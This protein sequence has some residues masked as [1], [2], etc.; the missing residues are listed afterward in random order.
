MKPLN[1]HTL[2]LQG[3]ILIEASAGTGKTYSISHI[4]LRLILE[5][6]PQLQESPLTIQD[7]LVVTFTKA[8]T[9][10]LRERIRR[11]LHEAQSYLEAT[12]ENQE[13][14]DENLRL[15]VTNA[16]NQ[17]PKDILLHRL[18][19]AILHIDEAPVFTIHGLCERLLRQ[20]GLLLRTPVNLSL[21]ENDTDFLQ[22]QVDDFWRAYAYRCSEAEAALVH[23]CWQSPEHL[24]YQLRAFLDEDLIE[25]ANAKDFSSTLNQIDHLYEQAKRLFLDVVDELP[26]IFA[27]KGRKA[28]YRKNW[29]EGWIRLHHNYFD[30]PS[31]RYLPFG[32]KDQWLRFTQDFLN[33]KLAQHAPSHPF[34]EAMNELV[35]HI[36]SVKPSFYA[37]ARSELIERVANEKQVQQACFF[38]DLVKRVAKGALDAEFCNAVAN[39]FPVALI[40]EFQ[41]TDGYQYQL[42][43]QIYHADTRCLLMIGDPKQAIYSFRGADIKTYLLAR[44]AVSP[45]NRYSLSTNHRTQPALIQQVNALFQVKE[46]PFLLPTFP[47]FIPSAAPN[48]KQ[49]DALLTMH[50]TPYPAVALSLEAEDEKPLT[51]A[52]AKEQAAQKTATWIRQLLAS[53][54]IAGS[55]VAPKSIAILVRKNSQ[56][57][58]MKKALL[59]QGLNSIFLSK[60]SVLRSDESLSLLRLF[61][62]VV[63]PASRSQLYL[64]LSDD[65]IALSSI[66]LSQLEQDAQALLAHQAHF[67]QAQTLWREKGFYSAFHYLNQTY[68]IASR[69]LSHH[70][71]ERKWMNLQQSAECFSH[72]GSKHL[73]I[74]EQ[75][76]LYLAQ[77]KDPR[78]DEESQKYRLETEANLINIVTVHG[79]KG[80]EYPIVCCP[81]IYEGYSPKEGV[82]GRVYDEHLQQSRITYAANSVESSHLF[83]ESIAEEI[84]LLYVALTRAKSHLCVTFGDVKGVEY[85]PMMQLIGELEDDQTPVEQLLA[86][87]FF[88]PP[89]DQSHVGEQCELLLDAPALSVARLHRSIVKPF[90]A[91]SFSALAITHDSFQAAYLD[92]DKDRD[93]VDE[94]E[95]NDPAQSIDETPSIFTLPKGAEIGNLLHQVLEEVNFR[96]PSE[97]D[98]LLEASLPNYQIPTEPWHSVLLSHLS[99][100]LTKTLAPINISLSDLPATQLKKEMGFQLYAKLHSGSHIAKLIANYRG[101]TQA[102]DFNP[103]SADFTGFIDL[104]FCHEDKYYVLDYKSNWLGESRSDYQDDKMDQAIESHD[105]DI[106]YILYAVALIRMLK[107]KRQD[108]QYDKH[109]GGVFYLFLRGINASDDAG[110]YFRKPSEQTLNQWDSLFRSAP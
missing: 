24:L 69:L 72:D 16:L 3:R 25:D 32:A 101:T 2:P 62:A 51:K 93:A 23:K 31:G 108:F 6:Q 106:Q 7:I 58:L 96:S 29:L 53:A 89:D 68:H 5:D 100:C 34:F 75:L 56:A 13:S 35:L 97:L 107:Q 43:E 39:Q 70:E 87:G 38:D 54:V 8:A 71:G 33:E 90:Y 10:E 49:D 92:S 95:Q 48:S 40:D 52:Q 55:A 83:T 1:F 59:A 79:S 19:V 102:G 65:L 61:N 105:Y 66:A 76:R 42:F 104:L 67:Y 60:E 91:S 18:S 9:K 98:A 37:F 30:D 63:T 81:F 94:T 11:L 50:H 77:L 99:M 27:V 17:Q 57:T 103:I 73:P 22:K 47:A 41:D 88:G 45:Q 85:S 84:R 4:V 109:F 12:G 28:K 15:L 20:H 21:L 110:I 46:N 26:D 86:L 36:L 82:M 14:V 80:L 64:A 44:D 78:D 74:E